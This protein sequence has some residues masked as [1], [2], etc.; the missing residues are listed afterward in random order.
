MKKISIIFIT[1]FC[2]AAAKGQEITEKTIDFKGKESVEMN[3]QIADSINLY[4][5]QKNEVF[6]R[7]S[8]N[9]NDNAD[10]EAYNISFEE[11]G[12]SVVING[13]F[14]DDYFKGRSNNCTVTDIYWKIYIPERVAFNIE[15]INGNITIGGVTDEVHAKSISGFI[16]LAAPSDRKADIRFSTI[17]GTIYTDH[18]LVSEW[19]STGI[20]AVIRKDL[21]N[22]GST[23]SLETISGDIFFRKSD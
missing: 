16:D 22:G 10:N 19:H 15:T 8:V 3:I 21:N 12:S 7:A 23:V 13:K 11:S 4:T 2:F 1:L 5:W 20:P 18:K 6:I 17:T 9:I 14:K